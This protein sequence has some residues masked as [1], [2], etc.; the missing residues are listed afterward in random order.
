MDC[1]Y[2]GVVGCAETVN[3]TRKLAL[4]SRVCLNLCFVLSYSGK[5]SSCVYFYNSGVVTGWRDFA[6]LEPGVDRPNHRADK[7][8]SRFITSNRDWSPVIIENGLLA[9]MPTHFCVF[10]PKVWLFTDSPAGHAG[11][12]FDVFAQQTKRCGLVVERPVSFPL[13]FDVAQLIS[14]QTRLG[15]RSNAS[16]CAFFFSA[17]VWEWVSEHGYHRMAV[18]ALPRSERKMEIDSAKKKQEKRRFVVTRRAE[19]LNFLKPSKLHFSCGSLCSWSGRL[20]MRASSFLY[21]GKCWDVLFE[22]WRVDIG[23]DEIFA[24]LVY[25]AN[26]LSVE[27]LRKISTTRQVTALPFFESQLDISTHACVY[28]SILQ[29]QVM[30]DFER[31]HL[32]LRMPSHDLS[33]VV[34]F[35]QSNVCKGRLLLATCR[36]H[37]RT[38]LWFV[39]VCKAIKYP[40]GF[41]ACL[42]DEDKF[43][44]TQWLT[45][46]TGWPP[47]WNT[48]SHLWISEGTV[49]EAGHNTWP[50]AVII[51]E[52]PR[53][54]KM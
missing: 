18:Q 44:I 19:I 14:E 8:Q 38:I 43:L 26:G 54:I 4:K 36:V 21:K 15:R 33:A 20:L 16:F 30:P 47:S 45:M 48:F 50:C 40:S 24:S 29:G 10:W 27:N 1:I 39:L 37:H 25:T 51:V 9:V 13:T 35:S 42:K 3:R 17:E 22:W 7:R 41:I 6:A 32:S 49:S 31:D 11:Q 2:I 5:A 34:L 28:G 53:G 12:H 52:R 46:E 23:R